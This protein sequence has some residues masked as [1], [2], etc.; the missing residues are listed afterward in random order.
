M[1]IRS[2]ALAAAAVLLLI[3]LI[4]PPVLAQATTA[5]NATA[6]LIIKLRPAVVTE[7]SSQRQAQSATQIIG[8]KAGR[9][10]PDRA[11]RLA[12]RSSLPLRGA[13]DLGNGMV[14]LALGTSLAGSSLEDTLA[15]LR[16]D[17]DVEFAEVD[18]RRYA[19]ALPSDPLYA[20]QWYLQGVET[21]AT[22]FTAAWDTTTGTADTVI[23]VLDTGIRFEHPDLAGRVLPGYDFVSGESGS[24]FVRANDGD[25]WDAD[26]SD[27]GDWVSGA[28]NLSGPLEGCGV[29]PSSWHGTR[30]AAMIGAATDNGAGIAGGTWNGRVLPVRVLG[31]CG[32]FDSDIIAGMRWAAGFSLADVPKNPTPARIL[33]L[34][35]GGSGSCGSAYQNVV[36]EL[37]AA[38]VLVVV[39]AGN[40][41]GGPVEVPGN[42]SGVL[43]VAGLRHVGTKVGFS[44]QGPQVG[45]SAP[46]GNCPST[47]LLCEYSLI[48][49]TNAGPTVPTTSTYTDDTNDNSNIGTSFSAPIVAAIAGLMHSVND[50]LSSAE[51]ITRIKAS[52]RP[53]PLPQA[54]LPTC[55]N[56]SDVTGS[57]GQCN[58]T[59]TT[60]GAG[61]ADAPGAIAEALRPMA[62]IV[63]PAGS[64]AG[65]NVSLNGSTSD[66]ARN[67]TIS[68]YSWTPVSGS[69]TF[70]GATDGPNVIVAVPASGQVKVRL[71]VADDL[72]STDAQEV[73]LGKAPS[74]GGGGSGATHPLM[75][76][77]LGL[78]LARRRRW[79]KCGNL[80]R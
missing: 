43:A 49:A 13:R 73:T 35:L 68:S 32:G 14:G 80:Q 50:G 16:A 37:T 25:D 51:F 55:P 77:A 27:P 4:T 34:S 72:G 3:T 26:A 39:S 57:L 67:R 1:R 69:P 46:G 18:Q 19:R 8:Q 9:S 63:A 44:S 47:P 75:L 15:A 54:G 10:G 36:T 31:K 53:F 28:E 59:T 42:C 61:I 60:C 45:I 23:A 74:S 66:A 79:N 76:L 2:V 21:S 41:A 24:S 7:A 52:A 40:S 62:R 22:N 71:A 78:L 5:T 29:E 17:P 70:V 11:R 20:S 48:T 6:R 64:G 30:V 56:T 58:C 12:E 38:G 65:Q 33:N